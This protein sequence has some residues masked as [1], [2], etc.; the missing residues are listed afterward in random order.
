VNRDDNGQ[1]CEY[2]VLLVADNVD[3]KLALQP[4]LPNVA[5]SG[6]CVILT[7][8]I[9]LFRHEKAPSVSEWAFWVTMLHSDL[10]WATQNLRQQRLNN[11]FFRTG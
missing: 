8:L 1:K 9:G 7:K 4:V 10:A 11:M 6:D 3:K 5:V 2:I